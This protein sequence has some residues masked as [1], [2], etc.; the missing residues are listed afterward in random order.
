MKKSWIISLLLIIELLFLVNGVL[1]EVRI[2]E[3]MTDPLIC[4]DSDCEYIEIYT[5]SP[6]NLTNWNINTTN[7]DYD[8]NFYLEDYLIIVAN[9]IVF[10]TNFSVN[11]SKII[12]WKGISLVNVGESVFLFNNNSELISNL[13]YDSST[14]GISWQYCSGNWSER[15]STPGAENN[16]PPPQNNNP[17]ASND[18]PYLEINWDEEDI[19]NGKEFNIDI[20]A[21]DLQ[22]QK[23]NLKI[24]I[25]F[26]DNDTVI[27]DRYHEEDEEWGSGIYYVNEFFDGGGDSNRRGDIKL[28]IRNDYRDFHGDAEICFKLE[29]EEQSKDCE[30]IEILEKEETNNVD[31]TGNSVQTNSQVSASVSPGITGNVIQLGGGTQ[32]SGTEDLKEQDNILYQSKT[33]LIKK[34][35]IYI[36]AFFCVAFSALLVFEKLK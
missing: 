24:W 19:V 36:F 25:K 14:S 26:E 33:E 31:T 18:E 27:S 2:N 6:I 29:G 34:Y 7:Q 21:F 17:P 32:N 9:K 13:T 16:C 11:E 30:N 20:D 15:S 35:A 8:F 22:S 1:G 4:P 28:R 23:Y 12:E 3:V 10:L 5:D